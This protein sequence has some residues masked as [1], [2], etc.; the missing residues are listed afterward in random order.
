MS[1]G[2]NRA[3]GYRPEIRTSYH[4]PSLVAGHIVDSEW[5]PIKFENRN[6]IFG[7]PS[8]YFDKQLAEHGLLSYAQAETIRWWFMAQAESE[9][10]VGALCLETRLQAY[11]LVTTYKVTPKNIT[12]A[13]DCRGK[14]LVTEPIGDNDE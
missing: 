9:R 2:E 7:V 4:S 1:S 8:G 6:D 14:P 10:A 3:V 12:G 5:R 13:I 11:D